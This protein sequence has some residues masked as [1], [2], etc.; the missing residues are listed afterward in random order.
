MGSAALGAETLTL[1]TYNVENY[2]ATNRMAEGTYHESYPKPEVEKQA[3][4]AVIRGLNADVLALQE[5]GP[6]PYLD[7]LRHDLAKEGVEYPYAE[8]LEAD[9]KERHLA[10]LSKKPFTAVHGYTQLTFK[11]F[12]TADTVKRGLLEL[13]FGQ[14]PGGFTLF[15]VHL[16]SR[17]TDRADDPNSA[18]RRLG[19]ATAVRDQILRVFPGPAT[20]RFLIVGD[21]NDTRA[22]KPLRALV[23]RGKTEIAENLPTADSRGE[24]WT[25]YFRKEETYTHVDHVLVSAG[26]RPAVE[27]GAARIYDAPGTAEASDH[28]PVTIRLQWTKD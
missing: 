10:V 19:E 4:R 26:L 3:L 11:Y 2:V 28:R 6:R 12:G 5:M 25:H 16:K 21:F 20:A 8:L 1:A 23:Q 14:G 7:E 15:V 17:F 27:N 24:T 9:D 22:S 18:L 13:R